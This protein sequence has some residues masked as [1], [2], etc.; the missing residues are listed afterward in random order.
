M[1]KG[2]FIDKFKGGFKHNEVFFKTE[3]LA[4]HRTGGRY[5]KWKLPLHW[6]QTR[7]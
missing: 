2:A 7:R 5:T 6:I 3:F 1:C 4:F